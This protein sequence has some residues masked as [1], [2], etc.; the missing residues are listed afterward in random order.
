MIKAFAKEGL[1][2]PEMQKEM[3][4][5]VTDGR[6]AP[7][8]IGKLLSAFCARSGSA[9]YLPRLCD[10]F[11]QRK[12]DNAPGIIDEYP[13]WRLKLPKTIEEICRSEEFA[14]AMRDI[15]EQRAL[16]TKRSREA[17][18]KCA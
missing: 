17:D 18:K 6:A 5:T 10:I 12:M 11:G 16:A 9:V 13:N 8:D 14:T 7:K 15:K 3:E 4:E 2:T 1:L